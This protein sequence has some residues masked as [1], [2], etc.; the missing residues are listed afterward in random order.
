MHSM[1]R[2]SFLKLLAASGLASALDPA[3]LH[4]GTGPIAGAGNSY[5]AARIVNEYSAFLPGER[6]ALATPPAI[7][8]AGPA[9]VLVRG[10][11]SGPSAA[12]QTVSIGEAIDGWRLVS[13]FDMNGTETAVFEK[14]VTHR[15][16]IAFVTAGRRTIALIPK[17][18]KRTAIKRATGESVTCRR[19][20]RS[21]GSRQG[22]GLPSSAVRHASVP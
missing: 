11:S 3:L 7:V 12:S 10:A 2:R 17:A 5:S 8:Q 18:T 4:A 13:I 14:H 19:L 9:G 6:A 15:G 1:E 20:P 16:A 22:N 21:T